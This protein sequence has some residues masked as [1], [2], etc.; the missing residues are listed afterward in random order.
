MHSYNSKKGNIEKLKAQLAQIEKDTA[1]QLGKID[2]QNAE[3]NVRCLIF[4]FTQVEI[5]SS[6]Q[7]SEQVMDCI[8]FL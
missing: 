6:Y 4:I 7:V 3:F 5:Y 8:K 2:S 1:E